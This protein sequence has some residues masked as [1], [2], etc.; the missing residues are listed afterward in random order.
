MSTKKKILRGSKFSS[1]HSTVI[2]AAE[3]VIVAAKRLQE[4]EKV[5]LGPIKV[6]RC[7]RGIKILEESN[8]ILRV[9]VRGNSSIQ[10]L[11]IRLRSSDD[12][13]TV[14]QSLT[15]AFGS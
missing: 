2:P 15:E 12:Q 10:T 1:S 7:T 3:A 14:T 6:T 8:K 9:T 11:W 5:V 4:V 13:E